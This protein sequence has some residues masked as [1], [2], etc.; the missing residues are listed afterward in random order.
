MWITRH[1]VLADAD[2]RAPSAASASPVMSRCRVDGT[3]I[4][5]H[6]NDT[7]PRWTMAAAMARIAQHLLV[8]AEPGLQRFPERHC[9]GSDHVHQRTTCARKTSELSFVIARC[10]APDQPPRGPR[11][12]CGSG[13]DHVA[14][15]TGFDNRQTRDLRHAP[16]RQQH[17]L[18]GR[19]SDR[20]R[21]PPDSRKP[22][23][24]I[25]VGGN[26]PASPSRIDQPALLVHRIALALNSLP[27][28]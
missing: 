11:K 22:A 25:F 5:R 12:S 26:A 21:P 1:R 6:R 14:N 27:E 23:A 16:C 15:G 13:G 18:I 20:A 8:T 3:V 28:N 2:V 9:L 7:N 24:I 4:I 10:C 19:S 17:N